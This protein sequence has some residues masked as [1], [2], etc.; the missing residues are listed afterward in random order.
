MPIY[1]QINIK[2]HQALTSSKNIYFS[3][4]P[5]LNLALVLAV[6]NG[7]NENAI[8]TKNSFYENTLS[9]RHSAKYSIY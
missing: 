3:I 1:I 9:A 7:C 8:T 4:A 6:K 5:V 2:P